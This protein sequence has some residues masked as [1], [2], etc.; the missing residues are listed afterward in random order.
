MN[1]TNLKQRRGKNRISRR[2]L[3]KLGTLTA[4]ALTAGGEIGHSSDPIPEKQFDT[5]VKSCCQFCQTRC[6]TIVQVK[7]GRVVNVYG[8]PENYWTEGGLCPKGQSMVEL[9]YSPHRLLH[10]L[11]R[12]GDGWKQISYNEA[13]DLVAEKILNLKS[14]SPGEYAHRAAMIA[15]LWESRESELVATMFMKLS[16]FPDIYHPG[17]T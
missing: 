2:T 13:V 16:G 6:T 11:K 5:E 17:D 1:S 8:N 15:P 7:N 4:G 12:E 3:I 10:P 9:T 14:G